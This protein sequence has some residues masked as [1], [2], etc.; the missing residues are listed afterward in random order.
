MG[1]KSLAAVQFSGTW[2]M[3]VSPG[4]S[5]TPWLPSHM[6]VMLRMRKPEDALKPSASS[7]L[8][9][10]PYDVQGSLGTTWLSSVMAL[11]MRGC[12]VS[13]CKL[14]WNRSLHWHTAQAGSLI[15]RQLDAA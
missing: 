3:A 14:N 11:A 9:A 2:G 12:D 4:G 5:L 13:T 15:G 1:A 7:L 8:Y 6:M 10:P